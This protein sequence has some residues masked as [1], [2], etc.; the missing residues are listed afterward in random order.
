VWRWWSLGWHSQVLALFLGVSWLGTH[1]IP[2]FDVWSTIW[3]RVGFYCTDLTLVEPILVGDGCRSCWQSCCESSLQTCLARWCVSRLVLWIDFVADT[4]WDNC[5]H[6]D[7]LIWER[8]R[9][10]LCYRVVSGLWLARIR[11]LRS[12]FCCILIHQAQLTK[13]A[14]VGCLVIHKFRLNFWILKLKGSGRA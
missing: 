14:V 11:R 1:W 12:T 8:G 4:A 7:L 5:Y 10:Y 6:A 2:G 9:N 3:R 13:K